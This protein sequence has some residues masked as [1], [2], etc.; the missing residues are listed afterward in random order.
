MCERGKRRI[1]KLGKDA[2]LKVTYSYLSVSSSGS[3]ERH[4]AD[5]LKV[6]NTGLE[7]HGD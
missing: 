3:A 7:W 4:E 6:D 5:S 2:S 1:G